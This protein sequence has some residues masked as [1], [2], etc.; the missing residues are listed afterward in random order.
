MA[1]GNAPVLRVFLIRFGVGVLDSDNLIAGYKP[2]RDAIASKFG[3]DDVDT[4]IQW[5]YGQ[6]QGERI[7][8]VVLMEA[9]KSSL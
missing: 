4:T 5:R 8:T 6:C 1:G 2:L 3:L 7:G 9:A